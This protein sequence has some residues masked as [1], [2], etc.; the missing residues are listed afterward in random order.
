MKDNN[1]EVKWFLGVLTVLL[2]A[3]VIGSVY[4]SRTGDAL[5]KNAAIE[6]A[7]EDA[8]REMAEE[9]D[10]DL[11]ELIEIQELIEVTS[12]RNEI[13]YEVILSWPRLSSIYDRLYEEMILQEVWEQDSIEDAINQIYNDALENSERE[14]MVLPEE[15]RIV[16]Q[17][18]GTWQTENPEDFFFV[19]P[20]NPTA[21]ITKDIQ[22]MT[23]L[24]GF[25]VNM[26]ELP[27]G[28]LEKEVAGA[29]EE[30]GFFHEYDFIYNKSSEGNIYRLDMSLNSF[31]KD[32]D[33]NDLTME[34]AYREYRGEINN[35]ED[36]KNIVLGKIEERGTRNAAVHSLELKEY[37]RPTDDN[38]GYELRYRSAY[39]EDLILEFVD[40]GGVFQIDRFNLEPLKRYYLSM[41]IDHIMEREEPRWMNEFN[42]KNP[43]S[44][45]VHSDEIAILF[46]ENEELNFQTYDFETGTLKDE[47]TLMDE[48]PVIL[49]SEIEEYRDYQIDKYGTYYVITD[50]SVE[51]KIWIV[52]NGGD[53]FNVYPSI[54]P[55]M[56][57]EFATYSEDILL[58]NEMVFTVKTHEED[59][60]YQN[61]TVKVENHT[62]NSGEEVVFLA[63][64]MSGGH[65][66]SREHGIM[67]VYPART[68]FEEGVAPETSIGIYDFQE[69][70][71]RELDQIPEALQGVVIDQVVS[72]DEERLLIVTEERD[73]W[74]LHLEEGSFQLS[75][76]MKER[77]PTYD[78][79]EN[80]GVYEKTFRFYPMEQG[81]YF[82]ETR[83]DSGGDIM[84]DKSMIVRDHE[85]TLHPVVEV[86]HSTEQGRISLA[87]SL[88]NDLFILME[89]S[90]DPETRQ[91]ELTLLGISYEVLD[92]TEELIEVSSIE[93]FISEGYAWELENFK[94]TLET[95]AGNYF[96]ISRD[97][98]FYGSLIDLPGGMYYDRETRDLLI[99]NNFEGFS[100]NGFLRHFNNV[101][102]ETET[103]PLWG[104]ED[105]FINGEYD[106]IYY[107]DER[108]MLVFDLVDFVPAWIRGREEGNN[109]DS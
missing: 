87:Y 62:Q 19:I 11:S 70:I 34:K 38:F 59:E 69:E 93:A 82:L 36:L 85:G 73:L 99:G 25:T 66:I 84:K 60:M 12:E 94:E 48:Y 100:M 90:H 47:V 67:V 23:E 96:T 24:M 52:E 63:E 13:S 29:L 81:Y 5:A 79:D 107:Q 15:I 43:L 104:Y 71:L 46:S 31:H 105:L 3:A 28:S 39:P 32:E 68:M 64:N 72:I 35:R 10:A 1:K 83:E 45:T 54:T 56:E 65:F 109:G 33:L 58:Y 53:G 75:G 51:E 57:P 37:Q 20:R 76:L 44:L 18:R 91:N 95:E 86:L 106:S 4:I 77:E 103:T 9:Y 26:D 41:Q 92:E 17:D 88:E 30:D 80:E 101:D 74:E 6:N 102:S 78:M 108:G 89:E 27:E 61:F 55:E 22:R 42:D 98:L 14:S 40:N 97:S 50:K 49:F 2:I 16:K 21:Y 8:K 7:F